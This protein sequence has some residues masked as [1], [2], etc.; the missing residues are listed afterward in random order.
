MKYLN[1]LQKLLESFHRSMST[2]SVHEKLPRSS[3]V[4]RQYTHFFLSLS[5]LISLKQ[6]AHVPPKM[7]RLV[8]A[9]NTLVRNVINNAMIVITIKITALE[10]H[11]CI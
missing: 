11:T 6:P 8:F 10:S 5:D 3:V 2:V 7:F 4:Q 9:A 1:D